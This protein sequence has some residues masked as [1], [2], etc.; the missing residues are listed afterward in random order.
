MLRLTGA[1]SDYHLYPTAF[2]YAQLHSLSV[3]LCF[4]VSAQRTH[5]LLVYM[6]RVS[7]H[8]TLLRYLFHEF[9]AAP[10]FCSVLSF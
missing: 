8:T 1:H 3:S 6:A 9:I 10:F 5:S 7:I 4:G 2:A